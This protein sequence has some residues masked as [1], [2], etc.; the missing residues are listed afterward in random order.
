MPSQHSK[1][2]VWCLQEAVSRCLLHAGCNSFS[3]RQEPGEEKAGDALS[4]KDISVPLPK[5]SLQVYLFEGR[6]GECTREGRR[7]ACV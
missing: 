2:P 4:E 7:A 5:V 6:G 3:R 1:T